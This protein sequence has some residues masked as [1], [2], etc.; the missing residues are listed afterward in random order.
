[1]RETKRLKIGKFVSD[2]QAPIHTDLNLLA[3]K[4]VYPYDYMNSW[5]RFSGTK[6]P[7]TGDFYSLL[8]EEN[9]TVKDYARA[10]IV[11]KHFNIKNLG[12]YRDLYLMT[13][14]Y[15]LTDVFETFRDMCLNY[16]GFRPSILSLYL[17]VLGMPCYH[18]QELDFNKST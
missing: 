13:D 16:Y 8:Y 1:M 6:L 15:L 2:I 4:G 10:N 11:W 5:E 12:E 17:I 18:K 14:V 7:K 9:I 3:D